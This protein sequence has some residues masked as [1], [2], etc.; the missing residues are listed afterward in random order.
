MEPTDLAVSIQEVA[1]LLRRTIDP[2]IGVEVR[3][4][5]GLWPIMADPAQIKQV[6]MNLCLNARDAMPEGGQLRLEATNSHSSRSSQVGFT[7][8]PPGGIRAGCG[9][10][11]PAP[12]FRPEICPRI[13][14]PFFTT[15]ET[16][17]GTGLGLA[18]VYG[19]VKQHQGWIECHSEAG[20]GTCFEAYLPAMTRPADQLY[21]RP[22]ARSS[23]QRRDD[24][25]GR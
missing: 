14:E 19:I 2:R 9:S 6:L 13:F 22:A 16:G 17:K 3:A 25:A 1:G 4:E 7:R 11:T 23:R 24:P 8:R 20:R 21:R 15:K 10:S 5:P 18:T 12:A